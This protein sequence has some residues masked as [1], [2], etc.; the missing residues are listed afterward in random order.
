[1]VTAQAEYIRFIYNPGIAKKDAPQPGQPGIGGGA[2]AAGGI[3][4]NILNQIPA[5]LRAQFQQ[6]TPAQQQQAIQQYMGGAGAGGPG[7]PGM[8]GLSGGMGAGARGGAR[9]GMGRGARGGFQGGFPGGMPGGMPGAMPGGMPGAMP[10]GM[11]GG[12][13][14]PGGGAPGI[15]DSGGPGMP[16]GVDPNQLVEEELDTTTIK[17]ELV[18]EASKLEPWKAMENQAYRVVHKWGQSAVDPNDLHTSHDIIVQ[19]I[20]ELDSKGRAR[21]LPT[22]A[23]R[24]ET[25]LAEYKQKKGFPTPEMLLVLAENALTHGLQDQ[26]DQQM[27]ALVKQKP[28]HPAAQAYKKYVDV[29]FK[30]TN[31]KDDPAAAW[32]DKLG[33]FRT[34]NTQHFL[35]RYDPENKAEVIQTYEKLLESNYRAFF[36]WF[37]LKGVYLPTPDYRL[38]AVL[39]EK[40]DEFNS[41]QKVFETI[42]LPAD[43]FMSRR[44][45]LSVM[46]GTPLSD[47][48][49]SL[50]RASQPLWVEQG[51][52]PELCLKGDYKA[53]GGKNSVFDISY[54]HTMALML[55]GVQEQSERQAV[56]HV[57][58]LQLATASGLLP[59]TVAAPHWVQFGIGS[60]FE[61]PIEAY[62]PGTGAPHWNY[63]TKFQLWKD[64]KKLDK[65]D[66]ALRKV[67][68]DAYF[69]DAHAD[70]EARTDH[71][72]DA[73]V[74]ARTMTW[75]L[76][77]FLA[78]QRLDQ[79]L[80]YYKELAGMPRDMEIGEEALAALFVKSFD[81]GEGPE[82]LNSVKAKQLAQKWYEYMTRDTHVEVAQVL[83]LA[84]KREETRVK[85]L[86]EIAEAKKAE[87]DAQAAA[88]AARLQTLQPGQFPMSGGAAFP[89]GAV[90]GGPQPAVPG[91]PGGRRAGPKRIDN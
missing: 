12:F 28:D 22:L 70:Q 41:L 89:G 15:M 73:M 76:T 46:S 60:F 24:W 34:K 66:E 45:N 1:M 59:R 13:A 49:D 68:T 83:A 67:V 90:P 48:Y 10:G 32:S 56:S 3:P 40:P 77:Y 23:A 35:I 26:F 78:Q 91:A 74:K 87:A 50:T 14:G 85:K 65:P 58:T 16:G 20:M 63:L 4:P 36:S 18:I 7:M 42:A 75:S 19:R 9:G 84:K 29:D 72:R 8:S 21:P 31:L 82:G 57:G 6:M 86:K 27:A 11:P 2:G 80:R 43:G 53:R 30:K 81:L 17:V 54:A 25:K 55:R 88:N 62:W 37:A 39:S 52:N 64:D 61:T 44:D 71:D 5:N 79:L 38:V 69:H 33:D 51:W 47:G